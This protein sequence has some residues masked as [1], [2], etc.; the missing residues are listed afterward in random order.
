MY[1][2]FVLDSDINHFMGKQEIFVGEGVEEGGEWFRENSFS[3]LIFYALKNCKI[4]PYYF[5]GLMSEYMKKW[6]ETLMHWVHVN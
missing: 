3:F 1:L 2:Q 6:M 4:I 5:T